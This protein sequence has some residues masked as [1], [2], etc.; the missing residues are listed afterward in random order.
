MNRGKQDT[1]FRIFKLEKK[2]LNKKASDLIV[3]NVV[4]AVLFAFLFLAVLFLLASWW[5][6]YRSQGLYPATRSMNAIVKASYRLDNETNDITR[7]VSVET[8]EY[9]IISFN[10]NPELCNDERYEENNC[11][12][13]CDN[14]DC[15]MGYK[16]PK[17]YCR[18]L[19]YPSIISLSQIDNVRTYELKIDKNTIFI[20]PISNTD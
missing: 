5:N 9:F 12:C 13:V 19:P 10:D 11:V 17:K 2:L 7:K 6:N 4:K 1:P 15:N 20:S 18:A 14:E 8:N 3:V 16:D